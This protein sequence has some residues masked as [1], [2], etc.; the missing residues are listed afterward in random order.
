[1]NKRRT[2]EEIAF[3]KK[4]ELIQAC[5]G[6]TK[7]LSDAAKTLGYGAKAVDAALRPILRIFDRLEQRIRLE[8]TKKHMH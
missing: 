6:M 8:A 3:E 1:M 7:M 5:R 4:I 2:A